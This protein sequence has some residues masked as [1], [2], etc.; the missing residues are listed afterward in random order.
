MD[1][2][3]S[4]TGEETF[5]EEVFN[6]L[7][8]GFGIIT[9]VIGFYLL[10]AV[11]TLQ[12]KRSLYTTVGSVVFGISLIG[13][14]T[15]STI[16]HSMGL[17]SPDWKLLLQKFDH[18]V[19][20]LVIAGTYTPLVT[21]LIMERGGH[22]KLGIFVLALE[23]VSATAGICVKLFVPISSIPPILSNGYYLFMGWAIVL[24]FKPAFKVTPKA[25]GLWIF[26]GGMSYSIGVGFLVFDSL[27]FNHGIWHI[28]VYG[29]AFFHFLAV[30]MTITNSVDLASTVKHVKD[31][32]LHPTKIKVH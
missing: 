6:T 13:V 32:M 7:T 27:W 11:T 4:G 19:I 29:G 18:C 5:H 23:W 28:F 14:F 20:Y 21:T 9:A 26:L 15:I 25:V 8:H 2:I 12:P 16:Y 3:L 24:I 10:V 30:L 17:I 1:I 22:Y 31:I